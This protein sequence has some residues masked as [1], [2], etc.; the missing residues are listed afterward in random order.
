ML[1]RGSPYEGTRQQIEQQ[2]SRRRECQIEKGRD[3]AKVCMCVRVRVPDRKGRIFR[4]GTGEGHTDN[5]ETR[6]H[7]QQR[8][9]DTQT[10][11]SKRG[12]G[13]GL[14]GQK[15]ARQGRHAGAKASRHAGRKQA[16]SWSLAARHLLI[17]RL[18][19]DPT[20]AKERGGGGQQGA[21]LGHHF[22][23]QAA[24]AIPPFLTHSHTSSCSGCH[25]S[26]GIFCRKKIIS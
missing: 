1:G 14:E 4:K 24:Q 3:T 20:C 21:R 25:S 8:N 2:S 18:P 26:V 7:R 11:R 12:Q 16:K 22:S 9:M 19:L 5:R 6:T 17:G 10:R 13:G 23:P 15:G